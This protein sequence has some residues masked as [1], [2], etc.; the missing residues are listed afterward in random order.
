[1]AEYYITKAQYNALDNSRFFDS[2]D[3]FNWFLKKWTG[4]QAKPYTGYAYYDAA[5]NYVG[6]S[7]EFD[8]DDLLKSAYVEVKDG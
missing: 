2:V 6:D 1:M 5:G 4:I 3:E 8:L 7:N